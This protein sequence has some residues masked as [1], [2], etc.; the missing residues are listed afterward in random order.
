MEE[1]QKNDNLQEKQQ[2]E[3]QELSAEQKLEMELEKAQK[4]LKYAHADFINYRNRVEK[5]KEQLKLFAAKDTLLKIL[6][7]FDTL[8]LA[9]T[10]QQ[11]PT[12][13]EEGVKMLHKQFTTVLEDCGVTIVPT[14]GQQF[15]ADKHEAL[16]SGQEADK[17]DNE[18]LQELQRGFMLKDTIL[19]AAKVKVNKKD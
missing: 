19:R 14:V 6:P 10:T 11:D 13:L 9:A 1:E 12:Q 18:I 3:E 4:E 17:E 7:L 8:H 5:E 16:M 2:N 15:D